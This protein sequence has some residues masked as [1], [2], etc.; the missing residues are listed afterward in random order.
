MNRARFRSN[1]I[2]FCMAALMLAAGWVNASE[3]D[4]IIAD[5]I[6]SGGT[7]LTISDTSPQAEAVAVRDRHIIAVGSME[8]VNAFRGE[9][10][11]TFDLNGNTLLPGFVDSH[12]HMI[13][14][15]FQAMSANLLAPPDGAGK[16][17]SDLI[18]TLKIWA[19]ENV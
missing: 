3:S 9:D 14:G 18:G 4:Q 5:T 11:E 8:D 12:G 1:P 2:A 19:S 17:I 15:G 6:Y 10:T 13:G 7:I 16:D